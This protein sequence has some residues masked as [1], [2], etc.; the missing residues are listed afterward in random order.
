M[1]KIPI[2]VVAVKASFAS[3]SRQDNVSIDFWLAANAS[4][5]LADWRLRYNGRRG[6][7]EGQTFRLEYS[8]GVNVQEG[9]S[10]SVFTS[11]YVLTKWHP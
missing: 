10:R 9:K 11:V 8:Q 2:K 5:H 7:A 4:G 6:E 1:A 3:A